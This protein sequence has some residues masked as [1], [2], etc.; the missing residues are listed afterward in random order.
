MI[1]ARQELVDR[2]SFIT[3]IEFHRQANAIEFMRKRRAEEASDIDG[4][5]TNSADELK[6]FAYE[7]APRS[8]SGASGAKPLHTGAR[9]FILSSYR[10][11]WTRYFTFPEAKRHHYELIPEG[12]P[13]H[14]YFDIEFKYGHNRQ[15]RPPSMQ[16]QDSGASD[17]LDGD[18]IMSVLCDEIVDY[19]N[20][21]FRF[22]PPVTRKQILQLDSSSSVKFSRHLIVRLDQEV[23]TTDTHDL[24]KTCFTRPPRTDI[25]VC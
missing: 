10:D 18:E 22:D 15:F 2:L 21:Q 17:L 12:Q 24:K 16:A 3:W 1:A 20:A 9:K 8:R 25:H 19:L 11:F 6:L 5:S 13:C 4:Q 14:L 23:A 7:L